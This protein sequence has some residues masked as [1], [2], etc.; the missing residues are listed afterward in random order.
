MSCPSPQPVTGVHSSPD[1]QKHPWLDWLCTQLAHS[2]VGQAARDLLTSGDLPTRGSLVVLPAWSW[3]QSCI[4]VGR[5]SRSYAGDTFRL[6]IRLAWSCG[7]LLI[8]GEGQEVT[9]DWHG[10]GMGRTDQGQ[11]TFGAAGVLAQDLRGWDD[12]LPETAMVSPESQT[13]LRV[14]LTHLAQEGEQARWDLI[15]ELEQKYIAKEIYSSAARIVT[16]I[17]DGQSS[18]LDETTLETLTTRF[19]YG[20]PGQE[21]PS[22]LSRLID[23][24]MVPSSQFHRVDPGR[25]L[26]VALKRD[27][28]RFIRQYLGDVPN[29]GPKIRRMAREMSPESLEALVSAYREQHPADRVA[30]G[31]AVHALSTTVEM[32][33]ACPT[34]AYEHEEAS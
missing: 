20:E 11:V 32:L 34:V 12:E 10:T 28:E 3:A 21:T 2:A 8:I 30:Q 33:L 27:T 13:A 25:W 18:G 19:V 15:T 17:T 9:V 7:P 5:K 22:P 4:D 6:P 24:A 1:S 26:T 14:E 16:E 23:H 29:V 31:R